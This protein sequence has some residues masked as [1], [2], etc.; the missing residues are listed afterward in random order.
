[1]KNHVHLLKF[2]ELFLGRSKK[3]EVFMIVYLIFL[4]YDPLYKTQE[5]D[6]VQG[7]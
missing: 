7:D 4:H 2:F 6:S 3:I 1:M 5:Q